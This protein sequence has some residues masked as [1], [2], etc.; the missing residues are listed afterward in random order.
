M[1][2]SLVSPHPAS[3]QNDWRC[4]QSGG[5]SRAYQPALNRLYYRYSVRLVQQAPYAI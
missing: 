2:L 4:P 1:M 3:G 5:F